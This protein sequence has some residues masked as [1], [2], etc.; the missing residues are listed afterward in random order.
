[1][2]FKKKKKNNFGVFLSVLWLAMSKKYLE[3]WRVSLRIIE[4][5][6]LHVFNFILDLVF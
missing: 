2:I 5:E 4:R 6:F 1:M 3:K